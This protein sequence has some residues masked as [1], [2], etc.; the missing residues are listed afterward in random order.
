MVMMVRTRLAAVAL[1]ALVIAQAVALTFELAPNVAH[2]NAAGAIAVGQPAPAF[3]LQN[4]NGEW[5]TLEQQRGKWLVLYFYP[6]D[7]TPGCTTQA[8]EFRD[9]IFAYRKAGAVILGVSVDDLASHKK[10]AA[11]HS[12]PFPILADADKK[13]AQRYGV[14]YKAMGI[15]EV[16]R[17]ETFIIDPAGRIARHFK[18]V[19]PKGHSELVLAEI[20]ALQAASP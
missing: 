13:T 4:Q 5:V 19:N 12:L 14:L 17:R 15:M 6:K 16:A 8:C 20:K 10:F 3:R 18:S 7:N 1:G 2:A 9:N 11:E